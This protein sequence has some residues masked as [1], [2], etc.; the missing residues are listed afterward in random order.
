MTISDTYSETSE[1]V[2]FRL[3]TADMLARAVRTV[4]M[5]IINAH[6]RN[7]KRRRQSA[8]DDSSTLFYAEMERRAERALG[9]AVRLGQDKGLI[10]PPVALR[11]DLLL[12]SPTTF[13]T[14]EELTRACYPFAKVDD[15]TWESYI[16]EA[17]DEGDMGRAN[18]IRKTKGEEAPRGRVTRDGGG[19]I[20]TRASINR[21]RQRI[22]EMAEAGYNS[23]Q[24][25]RDIGLDQGSVKNIARDSGIDIPA[26][27]AV[28]RT[29][30]IDPNRVIE[31]TVQV[32]D[33]QAASLALLD[34]RW[35]DVDR[36]QVEEW[37][38]SLSGSLKKLRSLHNQLK[39][40][41]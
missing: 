17:R 21:R 2:L 36:D 10:R 30:K 29:R 8:T 9:Q 31:D 1:Q 33:S 41:T 25:A 4:N 11:E 27:A 6:R 22:Q 38:S 35:A 39:E 37:I 19:P 23:H 40:L 7:A 18:L 13:A 32:I 24:I 20:K 14:P 12:P 5:D 28:A 15:E 26:D 3:S 16:T 34:G